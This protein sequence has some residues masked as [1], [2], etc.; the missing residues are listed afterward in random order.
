MPFIQNVPKSQELIPVPEIELTYVDE[1]NI[2]LVRFMHQANFSM[3]Y[4]DYYYERV[5]EGFLMYGFIALVDGEAA[6]EITVSWK[7]KNN[8]MVLYISTL[9]V[10]E[11]YR[12][13]GIA[14][15]L[16]SHVINCSPD[17][18]LFYLHTEIKNQKSQS[19]YRKLG[20]TQAKVISD[21]Y[22]KGE[23]GILMVKENPYVT[24]PLEHIHIWEFFV[25]NGYITCDFPDFS[26]DDDDDLSLIP[27]TE[28]KK[29]EGF[30]KVNPKPNVP[31]SKSAPQF[32]PS[33][34]PP[35]L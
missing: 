14:T 21:Y 10:L 27:E 31:R 6:G 32:I 34:Y 24:E 18:A 8:Q 20:F 4:E 3:N 26:D 35:D 23:D 7:V 33:L 16:M 15:L 13:R 9:S 11:Q 12:R 25:A 19:L 1:R 5:C 22:G 28:V 17:A 30:E 29:V 2:D